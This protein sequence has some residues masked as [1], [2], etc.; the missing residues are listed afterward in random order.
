M[1]QS[2]RKFYRPLCQSFLL[3]FLIQVLVISHAQGGR[4]I[5]RPVSL[6]ATNEPLGSILKKI[7]KSTG[8]NIF[9]NS[10]DL[11]EYSNVTISV[12][13]KL[14]TDVMHELL[15]PRGLEWVDLDDSAISV[16]RSPQKANSES[17]SPADSSISITGKVTNEKGSPLPGA[18]VMIRGT[19]KGSATDVNGN[20]VIN[21]VPPNA[22]L[23][24]SNISFLSK[25]IP[26]KG[27]SFLGTIT[28]Q[29]YIGEL[30]ETVIVAY[31]TTTNRTSTGNVTTIRSKD[32]GN[33]PVNNPILALAGRVP[34]LQITQAS[35]LVGGG[36]KIQIQGQNSIRNGNDPFYVID[37]VPYISQLLPNFGGVLEGAGITNNGQHG[38]PLSFIN[39]SDIESISVLKDADATA[40]YGS[41]A[42]NGAILIT[43]KRGK[44]GKTRVDANL[45]QGWGRVSRKLNLLNTQQYLTMRR[46]GFS[47]DKIDFS[48]PP[49]DIPEV[50]TAIAP[51]LFFWDTTRYTN[52]QKKFIGGTAKYTNLNLSFSGGTSNTHYLV[53]TTYRKESTVFPKDF[54]DEKGAVHFNINSVTPNQKFHLSL[55]ANYLVDNNRLPSVDITS[56]I[57]LAPNAPT[58][59]NND[60][61]INWALDAT[62]KTTFPNPM[63]ELE[64]KYTVKTNNLVSNAV[65]KYQI[66]KEIDISSSFGFTTMQSKETVITPNTATQPELRPYIL[67]GGLYGNNNISSWI[68]EPQINYQNTISKGNLNLLIGTSIQRTDANGQS[69]S[70]EGYLSDDVISDPKSASIIRSFSSTA[71][72]YK[73][74][75]LFGRLN[76]NWE[77]KYILNISVRRDGSSRFGAANRFHNFGAIGGAWILSEESFLK[78]M[79]PALSFLKLKLSYGTTGNDQIGNYAYLNLYT[80]VAQ[81]IPYQGSTIIT[82]TGLPNPYIQWEETRKLNIGTDFGFFN[83]ILTLNANYFNNR[84]S[85][86]LLNYALPSMAGGGVLRN[87]PATIRNSGLELVISGSWVRSKEVEWSSS[88]NITFSKNKLVSF[89][90]Q[91]QS[92]YA[93]VLIVG[94]SL[95][96]RRIYK[97]IGVNSET[98]VYEFS[99]S[100]GK[101]T[102]A[103]D[104]R[105]DANILIDLAPKYYGGL[106]NSIRYK[107]FT[108]D[109]LFQFVKQKGSDLSFGVAPPGVALLNQ[110]VA[111]LNR[112]QSPGDRAPIQQYSALGRYADQFAKVKNES[113]AG[114]VDASY[115]RL[116][117]LSAS[118]QIPNNWIK[119]IH[120]NSLSLYIQCQN[121]LTFTK[122]KG[123]D[124]EALSNTN[125]P[126]LKML[127]LGIRVSL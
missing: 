119:S 100:L 5:N 16:K 62:G 112:W 2:I 49:F 45:Q 118:W 20:F 7:T 72:I 88:I 36:V 42:A 54:V 86:Q 79:Q 39:I 69:Y 33:Q 30:D 123:L 114:Y 37:G 67:N 116:K 89:P 99:D 105:R 24:I 96:T 38:N 117:N 9:F 34:G 11:S 110:P 3:F 102:S 35:G 83:D 51:D 6:S 52:W 124:P 98:G 26:I 74:N 55:S 85:N 126:P 78:G 101:F 120:L 13:N 56:R 76:Y 41:K 28:L 57:F 4:V 122:Y 94:R 32:I 44:A 31:G 104:F 23:M 53:G 90:N 125:L 63:S 22:Y 18:T 115:I 19:N 111:V 65:L 87:F 29:G 68:I 25:S 14:F 61:S 50:R 106:N 27:R 121:L 43:T 97:Y 109:F 64:K 93:N 71:Y 73:Y 10:V 77:N 75:A 17:A 81:D 113:D 15:D 80:P 82:P 108:V 21:S 84:S 92:S 103:P 59:Y 95:S 70:G 8:I 107:N 46:E 58:L 12:K 47:N 91:E 40:I 127:T 1:P 48:S 60:G 66:T